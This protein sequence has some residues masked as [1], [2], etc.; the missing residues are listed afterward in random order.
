MMS[1]ATQPYT[2]WQAESEQ[3]KR[4]I[5][6]AADPAAKA[7]S[8]VTPHEDAVR[9]LAGEIGQHLRY[10]GD[11]CECPRGLSVTVD[12]EM[13]TE[14][15]LRFGVPLQGLLLLCKHVRTSWYPSEKWKGVEFGRATFSVEEV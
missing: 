3:A 12:V 5:Q 14:M 1:T 8:W 7:E 9:L 15:P 6:R 2:R 13:D 10:D 4:S 11:A